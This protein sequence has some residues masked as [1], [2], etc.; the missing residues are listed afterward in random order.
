MPELE[1]DLLDH[2]CCALEERF[3]TKPEASFE[4][5][6]P[7]VRDEV[8]PDGWEEVQAET[9]FLL[10]YKFEK[11]KRLNHILGLIG[12]LLLIIGTVFKMQYLPGA[13]VLIVCGGA[14][15]S[16]AY[17]PTM[18]WLALKAPAGWLGRLRQVVGPVGASAIVMGTLF[19]IMHWPGATMLMI[20]GLLLL[21][22][23]FLPLYFVTL[24]K[25]TK[26]QLQPMSLGVLLLIGTTLLF[27]FTNIKPSRWYN[28]SLA[29]LSNTMALDVA[30]HRSMNQ[31]LKAQVATVALRT[32]QQEA[33]TALDAT[34]STLMSY[35]SLL[36][37]SLVQGINPAASNKDLQLDHHT[38]G[39]FDP[40]RCNTLL[41]M[42]RNAAPS[43]IEELQ[44]LLNSF[45]NQCNA[46]DL[47]GAVVPRL[48]LTQTT[49]MVMEYELS[50]QQ[51]YWETKPMVVL[52]AHLNQI[53]LAVA[54]LQAEA[55]KQALS[56]A[57][58]P[59]S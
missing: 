14:V 1:D 50:W 21:G 24:R 25:E 26:L 37:K 19:K 41:L 20:G 22:L 2:V 54:Q 18:L 11:M 32:E 59:A 31:E 42:P 5:L 45:V 29:E 23:V 57:V 39:R 55:Y 36:K 9:T 16:L 58:P 48:L 35:T 4:D 12:A 49:H 30:A 46:L 47:E 33:L 34:S 56:T 40:D 38:A 8:C 27:S 53:E 51:Y 3:S 15:I 13:G 44:A 43:R 7:D 52:F 6:Y 17:F 28:I 10:T